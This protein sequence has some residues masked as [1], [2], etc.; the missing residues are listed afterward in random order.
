MKLIPG[1]DFPTGGLIIGK[2]II[3]QGYK[4]GR[5]SFKIRGEI[6]TEQLKNGKKDLLFHQ[7]HIKLINLF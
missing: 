7:F 5:G 6:S 4:T 2:D 3:K 1:P